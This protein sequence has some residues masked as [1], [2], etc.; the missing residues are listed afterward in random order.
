MKHYRENCMCVT[1]HTKTHT[2]TEC[3]HHHH[4]E[5]VQWLKN[6]VE[7]PDPLEQKIINRIKTDPGFKYRIGKK[8]HTRCGH[9]GIYQNTTCAFCAQDARDNRQ[10][11]TVSQVEH[12]RQKA[13]QM[14]T[15]LEQLEG[16]ILLA[17]MGFT[18]GKP[19]QIESPRQVA[20]REGNKW[21]IPTEPCPRCHTLS[22]RYVLNGRCKG[23]K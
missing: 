2:C 12:L 14:R 20:I 16:M 13:A 21:Y 4:F 1:E 3:S 17:E 7:S 19:P 22:E 6:N 11:N 18:I 10:T 8:R 9:P 23:C 5:F 15:N